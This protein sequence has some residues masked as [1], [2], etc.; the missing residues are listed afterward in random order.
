ME[1]RHKGLGRGFLC[2]LF[3]ANYLLLSAQSFPVQIIPQVSPPPPI[4]FSDYADASTVNGPLRV[5]IILNDFEI[6]NREIRLRTYFEGNG[7]SF[8]S[9]DLVIGAS[10]LFLEGGIPLVLTNVE[11]APYFSIENITGISPQTYGQSIP[12]GTYRFCFE[13]YDALT[14]NR[15]SQKSCA[16]SA[17]FQNEPPFLIAPKNKIKVAE[18]NP[19]HIIFQWTPRSINVSNVAYEL[20]LIEIWDTQVNPQAAFFSS[21]PIFQVTTT[22]TTYVYGP[23]DPLLLPGKNY[24]W[25]IRVRAKQG[26]DE[27][28]LFK[29]QGRSEIF[30]FSYAGPCNLPININHEVKGSTNV[31]LIWDDFSTDIPEYTVRYRKK[32]HLDPFKGK[33]HDWFIGKTTTNQLTLWDLTAGTTYE[34]QVQKKCT[35]TD[36]DWSILKE[37]STYIDNNE[38]S[39]YECGIVPDFSL[40]NKDPLPKITSGKNFMAGDFPITITKVNGSNGRFTGKGYVTIPYLNNIR[41]GVEFTN[42]LLNTDKQLVKGTVVTKYDPSLKSILDIDAVAETIDTVTDLVTEPLEGNNDLDEIRVNFTIPKDSIGNYIIVKDGMVTITNPINGASIVEPLGDD[43]VVIDA[44]GQAYHIDASGNINKGGQIDPGGAIGPNTVEGL[45]QNG[46][47]ERLTAKD[48]KIMFKEVPGIYGFDEL[49]SAANTNIQKKYTTIKDADGNDYPLVHQ[50][51]ANSK[52]SYIDAVIEQSGEHPYPLDSIVFKTEQGEKLTWSKQTDNTLRLTLNGNYTFEHEIIYAVVPSRTDSTKQLTAGAFMLW[53]MTD[54]RVDV[55]LLSV[56]GANIPDKTAADISNIFK[57]GVVSTHVSIA[58]EAIQL[59]PLLLGPNGKLDIGEGTWLNKYNEEQKTIISHLRSQIDYNKDNYYILVFGNDV[60]PSKPIGGFMPFQHQFGFVF[61]SGLN[62]GEEGKGNLAKT[63]AHE[64][65]HGAFALQHPFDQ[66]GKEIEGTTGWLMDHA[67]GILLSHMDWA[68][69]H[70]PA[71][72]LYVFQEDEE[73]EMS[74]AEIAFQNTDLIQIEEPSTRNS[75]IVYISPAGVPVTLPKEAIPAFYKVKTTPITAYGVLASF[76]IKDGKDKGIY[77]GHNRGNKFTGYKVKKGDEPYEF[78]NLPDKNNII[79]R[80]IDN[81]LSCAHFLYEG[82]LIP[83]DINNTGEGDLIMSWSFDGPADL[84]KIR[85]QNY[86]TCLPKI[87]YSAFTQYIFGF[88]NYYGK[89]GFLRMVQFSDGQSIF[90]YTVTDG[91]NGQVRHYQFNPGNGLWQ[92]IIK[93]SYDIRTSE[94]LKYLFSHLYSSTVGHSIL[95]MAGM[96]PVAGELFDAINGAWYIL[97]GNVEDAVI[98]FA[99]TIPFVYATTLKNVGKVVKLSNGS[100]SILK[101]SNNTTKQLGEVIK[102]LEFDENIFKILDK[103]LSDVAFAKA[104]ADDP[105]LLKSWKVLRLVEVNDAIRLGKNGEIEQVSKYLVDNPGKSIDDVVGEIRGVGGY[106]RWVEE[107]LLGGTQLSSSNLIGIT[108]KNNIVGHKSTTNALEFWNDSSKKFQHFIEGDL[109]LKFDDQTGSLLFGN[110]KNKE[111]LG[112]YEGAL[113]I[114]IINEKGLNGILDKLKIYHGFG[115]PSYVNL[116]VSS[117]A[118]IIANHNK[119]TT[120]IG[121]YKRYPWLQGD[122][123]ELIPELLGNLNTQQF[124]PK[125]GGFNILN[126]SDEAIESISESSNFWK[127]FN[128]PWLMQAIERK[129]DIWTASNPMELNLIFK[130]LDDIPV[131]RIRNPEDLAYYLKKLSDKSVLKEITNFGNELKLLFQYSYTYNQTLK[132]FVK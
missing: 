55:V 5:Q 32:S 16:I 103:D 117:G 128:E 57:K 17:I 94:N 59:D 95:D 104:L 37:F 43:K 131:N 99:S 4:Y 124:G 48:I 21:P 3:T 116:N 88:Y 78:P 13:V 126:I 108:W 110:H 6:A 2:L 60:R 69:L 26:M 47:L 89:G 44:A 20:S 22:A 92:L 63:I 29:N 125:K 86:D 25:Q 61:S 66:Y 39:V 30:S 85:D 36:S 1:V 8:R 73:A 24:A 54:R 45:S 70:N 109:Y 35:V 49:P 67:D 33:G 19:Q 102:A 14:G 93:P 79:V 130:N 111:I 129:D 64:I 112:F 77:L 34:Y 115:S 80:S 41:V 9:N 12:E 123:K 58:K 11:L 42:I 90:I 56:N 91:E 120:I 96:A 74:S 87:D 10:Q 119:T 40:V 118:K 83:K 50:A 51:V 52:N 101:F 23:S 18:T 127:S 81:G 114:E 113:N 62:A 28:G 38:S 72:K 53:H 46:Q 98:S 100:Y 97:E 27:V 15:L 132:M 121:N 107:F 71:L 82:K 105:K 122:M 31:N 76:T 7:I 84:L 68:Q 65:G 75:H 106:G